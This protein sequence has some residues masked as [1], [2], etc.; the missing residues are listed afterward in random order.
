MDR[1]YGL[2]ALVQREPLVELA[3]EHRC[4]GGVPVV[5]MEHVALEALGQ[6]LQAL[7]HGLR[8]EGEAL[9]VIE[10]AIGV[11]AL[12]VAL[13]IDE[14]VGN[15][16]NDQALQ[17]AVLVPPAKAHVEV[18]DVL[19]TVGVLGGDGAVFGHHDDHVGAGGYERAGQRSRD[20]AQATGL[21]E[22]GRLRR[23]EHHL[24]LFI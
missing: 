9:A 3:E 14:E 12:E 13:V 20:I 4:E 19:H 24:H 10:E 5:A 15:A 2:H 8:E 23:G 6:V 1:E 7:G 11:V 18:G 16:V 21:D 22:R 17:A